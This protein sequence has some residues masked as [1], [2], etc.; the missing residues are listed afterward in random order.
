MYSVMKKI[1]GF[2]AFA[3]FLVVGSLQAQD[4][5]MR[6]VTPTATYAIF[7]GNM[8]RM[9]NGESQTVAISAEQMTE[10]RQVIRNSGFL[11]MEKQNGT[12]ENRYMIHA[13]MSNTAA[14]GNVNSV[15]YLTNGAFNPPT[16]FAQVAGYLNHLISLLF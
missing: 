7:D 12:G 9:E 13:Q 15:V 4:L 8:V 3:L 16:P 11:T 6:Y 1:I 14:D 10:L 5:N 2:L